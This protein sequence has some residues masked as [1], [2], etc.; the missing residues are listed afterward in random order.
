MV[1]VVVVVIVVLVV[2]V[3]GPVFVGV[4]VQVSEKWC[5]CGARFKGV[6]VIVRLSRVI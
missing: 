3:V 6:E 2:V 5:C 4:A 1:E